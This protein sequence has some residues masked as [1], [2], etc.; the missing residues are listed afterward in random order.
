METLTKNSSIESLRQAYEGLCRVAVSRGVFVW[1]GTQDDAITFE[2]Q[3]HNTRPMIEGAFCFVGLS[4]QEYQ[5]NCLQMLR[6]ILRT[7]E[8]KRRWLDRQ[9][10][11][12]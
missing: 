1:V 9:C 4:E 8:K 7:V 10:R 11:G 2:A 6:H 5:Y 3:L 12:K